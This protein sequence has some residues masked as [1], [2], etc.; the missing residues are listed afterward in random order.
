VHHSS[1]RT[2]VFAAALL[3]LGAGGCHVL[4]FSPRFAEGE[5]GIFDDLF[6]VSVPDARHAVAVGYQGAAYWTDDAGSTWHTGD[7]PTDR[8]LYSVSMADA[9]TGWAVGQ[10][11]TIIRTDDG[12][13][14]WVEQP[15]LKVEE[16]FHIFGIHAI[17]K[18]TAWAVGEWGTRVLTRDG[19]KTWVDYSLGV[20]TLHPQFVWLTESD[21]ER[22]RKGEKVYE[23]VGLNYVTCLDPPSKKCWLIGEF[24]YIFWSDDQGENWIRSEI[25]GEVHLEPLYFPFNEIEV[26]EKYAPDLVAFAEAIADDT[27][28]NVKVD[29]FAS[30]Q[31]IAAFGGEED[32]EVLFDLLSARIQEVRAILDEAGVATDRLRM[33]NKPPWD[34]EDFL[35]DDPAF[36][37]RYLEGRTAARGTIKVTVIQNPFLFTIDFRDEMNGF[38]AGLGGVILRSTDGGKTFRYTDTGRKQAL[39]SV[40]QTGDRAVA[41]GEKGLVR[42]STDGG[43]SWGALTGEFPQIFTFMRDIDFDRQNKTGLIVGQEGMVLRSTDGGANWDWV[44][45]PADRRG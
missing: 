20:D 23:D 28:V 18:D 34:F 16:S 40:A 4:D 10:L 19:G 45:P 13:K 8:L 36:L 17:D 1:L 9:Q 2:T 39:F 44:L 30:V 22:V 29:P 43:A 42:Q 15:N 27:H 21:Q 14:T 6:S 11:G 33:P 26:E 37:R 31:E 12:G 41:I 7:T 5:I 25:V 35:E 38:I 3:A 24:G 32:P